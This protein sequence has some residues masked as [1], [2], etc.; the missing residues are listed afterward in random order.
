M[1]S[2][3]STPSISPE[4][5]LLQRGDEHEL[6]QSQEFEE[7]P[8]ILGVQR[9][10]LRMVWRRL[11][12]RRSPGGIRF[13]GSWALVEIHA[14]AQPWGCG[15]RHSRDLLHPLDDF[16]IGPAIGAKGIAVKTPCLLLVVLAAKGLGVQRDDRDLTPAV[17][18]VAVGRE[19]EDSDLIFSL[20]R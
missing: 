2:S 11:L 15:T 6:L 20:R 5:G 17:G 3:W 12:G 4:S 16:L 14:F 13:R 18:V 19:G 7:D 10:C 1:P 8:R 9:P